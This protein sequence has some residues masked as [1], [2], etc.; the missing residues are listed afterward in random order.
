MS[1]ITEGN[2]L[3]S[4]SNWL[5][6]IED[7]YLADYV[8]SGGS[9]VKVITGSEAQLAQTTA[10]LQQAATAHDCYYAHLDPAQLDTNG[11]RPDLHRIERF[12]FAVT[13]SVDWKAWAAEQARHYLESCGIHLAAGRDLGDLEQ[14]ALDNGRDPQDLINQF[15]REL[16]TPQIRD[17]RLSLEFRTAVTALG[18]ALLIPDAMTPTTEEV[19]LGWFRG[20][21]LPGASAALKKVQIYERISLNNARP[22]LMSFCR[23]LPQTG[24]SGLVVTLD[25]R[26][27]EYKKI[28]KGKQQSEQLQQIREALAR[29]ATPDEI[30]QLAEEQDR[31]QPEVFYS[32]AAYMQMLTLIRRFIDEIDRFERFLLVILTSPNFYKDKTLDPTIK[33]CYFDYDALQTRI[34]Q[35]VHDARNANPAASLVHL[36]GEK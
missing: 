24:H 13:Q 1:Q 33:R 11:K 30:S 20:Q 32:D 31:V 15:Q 35:E 10:A 25:F 19:L 22:Q 4:S 36:G 6:T 23:W 21:S 12:F 14:I 16:A 8:P 3:L 5:Q 28:A 18:R 34:G 27:Y 17:T 2:T 7:E 26:P 9:A 29:G